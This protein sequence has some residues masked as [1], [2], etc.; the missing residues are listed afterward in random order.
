MFIIQPFCQRTAHPRKVPQQNFLLLWPT[1]LGVFGH[2]RG[3]NRLQGSASG[4]SGKARATPLA[5][6]DVDAHVECIDLLSD[7]DSDVAE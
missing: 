3:I 5:M 7:Y 4:A 6:I 1:D 2:A